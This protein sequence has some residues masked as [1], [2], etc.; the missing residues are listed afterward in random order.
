M[1]AALDTNLLVYA[2]G[3]GDHERVGATWVLLERLTAADL[4]GRASAGRSAHRQQ[5]GG[6]RERARGCS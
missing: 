1:R 6:R 5:N 3:F 2:E 4:V